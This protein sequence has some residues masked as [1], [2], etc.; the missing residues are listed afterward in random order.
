MRAGPSCTD[1]IA[2]DA[3]AGAV[4]VVEPA[5]PEML[6]RQRVELRAGG[7]AG[8]HRACDGDM[9]A[10]ARGCS[11]RSSPRVGPPIAIVRVTSVVPSS[12]LRAAIDQHQLAVRDAP[13]GLAGDAV[14]H[15]GAVR[16][17]A[18]N[19]RERYVPQRA[20]VAAKRF[21]RLRPRR[22]RSSLPLAASPSNQA[23]KRANADA[24]A[25]V[26]GLHAPSISV[27]VLD[28]LHQRDRIAAAHRLAVSVRDQPRSARRPR[29]RCRARSKRRFWRAPSASES[30]HRACA[31]RRIPPDRRA[32]R[33][34]S[35]R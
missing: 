35:L 15:D 24:V 23:R 19:G 21:Q 5:C 28:G 12:I 29:W 25:L 11:G 16:P 7:A 14:M 9:A 20:G 10:A 3:V 34:P 8:K 13:V 33:L 18:G 17:G 26:R 1:E 32:S 27:V 4:V 6:A 22:S 30:E 31:R 2:A